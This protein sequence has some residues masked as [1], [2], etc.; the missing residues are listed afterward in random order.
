MVNY[1]HKRSAQRYQLEVPVVLDKGTGVTRDISSSGIYLKTQE[2]FAPG[3]CVRFT[4][5]LEFAISD[6]PLHFDCEGRVL[7]VEKI[8]DEYGVASTIDEMRS[9]H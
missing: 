7:R 8:G 9:L 3:D 1:P 4:F 2:S 5:V 6:G